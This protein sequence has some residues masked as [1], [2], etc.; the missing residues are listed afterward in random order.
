LAHTRFLVRAALAALLVL[1]GG[2]VR[3]AV[4][5]GFVDEAVAAPGGSITG[6][7]FTPDGRLLITRQDGLLF[8]Y[9]YL[10][11]PALQLTVCSQGERGLLGV[12]VDPGFA[13]NRFIYLYY[14]S[15]KGAGCPTGSPAVINRVSQFVLS[16]AN[17]VDPASEQVLVDEI[18]SWATNHNGGD[19]RFGRDGFL[20]VSVGDGGCDYAGDSGCG[21]GNDAS[22]DQ[23]VLL[24]K[25][26]RIA[27]AG[28][29]PAARIPATNPFR[30]P[31][32]EPCALAG[33]TTTPGK[34]RCQE[35]YAWGFRNPFRIA[36][37][38]A[39]AT[40]R[41]F[42][43]DVGQDLREEI[44]EGAAGADYGWNCREGTFVNS[45]TGRCAGLPPSAFRNPIYEYDHATGCEAITGGAFV[46]AGAWPTVYAGSYLFADFVCSRIFRL[47]PSGATWTASSF[48]ALAGGVTALV[49]GPPATND[50]LFY[51]TH[52]GQIRRIRFGA[53]SHPRPLSWN[54]D[55][56]PDLVWQ[57]GT[58][59][60]LAAWLMNGAAASSAVLLSP[61]EVPTSWRI[62]GAGDFN[63][64]GKPDLVWQDLA[65][66]A[67][68]VWYMNGTTAI[69]AE[70]LALG[71]AVIDL[72]GAGD[73]DR[74]GRPD[75][76]VRDPA[77]GGL[78]I[79]FM[80]GTVPTGASFLG[81]APASWS[82]AGV[83]DFDADGGPDL[84][85]QDLTGGFLGVS[86]VDAG[87]VV[88][89]LPLRPAAVPTNLRLAGVADMNADGRPDLLWQERTTGVLAVWY[90]NGLAAT[91]AVL[92]TP[93]QV[94]SR[95]QI[96]LPR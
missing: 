49:F 89:F 17:V 44:D 10:P 28:G 96:V 13:T 35:T 11:S 40:G 50:R 31:D 27:P 30:G 14:T 6:L 85:W 86:F 83:A 65:T 8:V 47:A 63:A 91:N 80:N 79:V 34:V 75:L 82:L 57:D 74:D 4:P 93:S 15:P 20:Y 92:L 7:A 59:G 19:L 64:D 95:W 9:P 23:Q 76:V 78:W 51:A 70:A 33:R 24:G 54:G 41:F 55:A 12:A 2:A 45:T 88:G 36:F 29:T 37:D 3:A 62:V 77:S 46:P 56:Q 42:I 73:F 22:R 67:A 26:L 71:P 81:I 72:R 38:P 48:A 61:S 25:I 43:N 16:D 94:D 69:G 84:L 60:F 39:S 53:D 32:S 52:D 90:M 21:G 58:D 87:S 18:P 1:A 66:G 68:V 5:A